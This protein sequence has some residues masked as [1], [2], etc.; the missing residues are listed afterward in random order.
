MFLLLG[1]SND[2]CCQ[3]VRA[4]LAN[5]DLDAR[6]IASPLAPPARLTWRLDADGLTS[7]LY[8]QL[9]HTSI[10]GVL[11]R[12]T[13]WLDPAGWDADDHAYMQAELRA[14]TSL[15]STACSVRSSTDRTPHWYRAGAPI[16]AWRALL[17]R[18][19]LPLPEV[20]ITSDPAEAASFPPKS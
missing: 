3:G 15:G 4:E 13:G 16:L 20:L 12:D 14:V 9:P 1:H 17:R 8:P 7:S 5:H 11:V 2:S 6:I 10:A 18:S 19:G